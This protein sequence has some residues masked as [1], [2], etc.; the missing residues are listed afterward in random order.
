MNNK[1][2][3]K[4]SSSNRMVAVVSKKGKVTG[5][6]AGKATITAKIGKK[7]YKCKVVVKKKVTKQPVSQTTPIPKPVEETT[8][9]ANS[10]N[11]ES[12]IIDKQNIINLTN[13]NKVK[14]YKETEIYAN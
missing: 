7:K 2:K 3:V 5:K 10:T 8:N 1:K 14:S 11:Q 12:I 6:K 4:W 13:V 9:L